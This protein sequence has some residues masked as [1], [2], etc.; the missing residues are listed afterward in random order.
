MNGM[1]PNGEVERLRSQVAALEQLLEVQERTALEQTRQLGLALEVQRESERQTRLIIETAHDAFISIN[2]NGLIADWNHQAE[3]I[4]GWARAEAMGYPLAEMI[5]PPQHRAAH[6]RGLQHFLTTGEGPVLNHRIE[7]TALHR[8][9]REFPVELTI[10]PLRTEQGYRFNAFIRDITERQQAEQALQ[11][12]NEQLKSS[13]NELEERTRA[14]T[15][16]SEMTDLLQSCA[17]AAEAYTVVAQSATQLFPTE[18]GGLYVFS[19]S[20]NLVEEAAVWGEAP[21]GEKVF[22]PAECWALR[23]GRLHVMDGHRFGLL[24]PHL[25]QLASLSHLCV[26]MLAHGE[27]LGVL[28][29]QSRQ[30]M[31][32]HPD[33]VWERLTEAKQRLAVST[34]EHIGLSLANLNLREALRVQSIRDPLTGLFNRRYMEESL[35]RELHRAARN[36]RPLG[37]VMLDLDHYKRFNDTFGHAAGDTMLRALSNCLQTHIRREDIACRYGGE[38]FTLILPDASRE[39][40]Q[41]RA[42]RLRE[43]VKRL[44]V[45]HSGQSLGSVTLS[46]GIAVFPEHGSTPETLLRAADTALYRAKAEGRDRVVIAQALKEE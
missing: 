28:Y 29:M 40:M 44:D 19:A 36:Q 6:L 24:C 18:T 4:F 2:S 8:D 12:V 14:I 31:L 7:I 5:I 27:T 1:A 43:E 41:Q 45:Q 35:E 3:I 42:E 20:R 22:A 15:V 32:S 46:L 39:V 23:R 10:W 13:V 9:G 37:L 33:A 17:N 25:R 34:A 21:L 38:E 11:Q 26:P 16:L 30:D